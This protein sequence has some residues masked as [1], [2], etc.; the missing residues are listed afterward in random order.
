MRLVLDSN[1][2]ITYVNKTNEK[3]LFLT[4]LRNAEI[5][6]HPIIIKEVLRNCSP[7]TDKIFF[8]VIEL[9]NIKIMDIHFP[10]SML[11]YYSKK[12]LKKGDIAI[13]AF[14]ESVEADY[15]ISE[16]RHFLK[17]VMIDKFKVISLEDFI[18]FSSL[19]PH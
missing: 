5:L 18:K 4:Y 13:A 3:L 14:C 7:S 16:N 6:I 8:A 10:K 9:L 12:G 11:D 2:F 15:L 1:E 19:Q 17:E